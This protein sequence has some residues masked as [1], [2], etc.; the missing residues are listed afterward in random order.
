MRVGVLG[1]G[2]AGRA[3]AGKL[4]ELGHDVVVG[5]RD[6]QELMER[7]EPDARGNDPFATWQ[8]ANTGVGIGT[9]EEAA[10]H[11]E[12]L[13]NATNGAASLEALRSVGQENLAGKVLV[14]ISNPV[15]YSQMPP[16][17]FVSNTDSLAEQIQRE[18]PDARVVKTL[19]T[20]TASVMVDP[21]SV[22][23]GHHTAFVS[24][25]DKFAKADVIALL[26]D[27]FGWKDVLD[28]GGIE[29]A[30]AAEMYVTLWAA[31]MMEIGPLFNVSV[32]R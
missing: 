16:T 4:R 19:N 17:L 25:D 30:R 23:N 12:L 13:V 9:F 26:S 15:D 27:G 21:G 20:V 28:L 2:Q 14:D 8:A 22:G 3:I 24:G 29:T 6:P 1:T 32:V 31:V 10:A 18:F 7:T 5:T 11:G